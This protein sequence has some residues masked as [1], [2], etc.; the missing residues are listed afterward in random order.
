M[1]SLH[2]GN[3]TTDAHIKPHGI[4]LWTMKTSM[5][6][7]GGEDGSPHLTLHLVRELPKEYK[8]LLLFWHPL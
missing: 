5:Q 2:T 3:G 8:G 1:Y 6:S 7:G 4:Q